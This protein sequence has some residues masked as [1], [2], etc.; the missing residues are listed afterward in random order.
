MRITHGVW[1]YQN[2]Y[3]DKILLTGGFGKRVGN[4]GQKGEHNYEIKKFFNS[5][6]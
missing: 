5:S 1:L 4:K 3:V 6:Q 2:D